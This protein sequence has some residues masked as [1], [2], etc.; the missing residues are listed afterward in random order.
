MTSEVPDWQDYNFFAVENGKLDQSF[1]L[2]D[3]FLEQVFCKTPDWLDFDFEQ[4]KEKNQKEKNQLS[5]SPKKP[6]KIDVIF[7]KNQKSK[8]KNEINGETLRFDW[9][10]QQENL[11]VL[12]DEKGEDFST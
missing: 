10:N 1:M 4:K 5:F 8:K 2:H 9:L 3:N 11:F 6:D 7:G 12:L